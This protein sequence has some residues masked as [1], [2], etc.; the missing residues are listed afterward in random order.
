[1]V[2][3]P[4]QPGSFRALDIRLKVPAFLVRLRVEVYLV[5]SEFIRVFRDLSTQL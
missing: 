1:M 3:Q 2:G 4:Y 5:R